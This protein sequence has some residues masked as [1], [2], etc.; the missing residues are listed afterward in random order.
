MLNHGGSMSRAELSALIREVQKRH[1]AVPEMVRG[2]HVPY[3]R[4]GEMSIPAFAMPAG[5]DPAR[6]GRTESLRLMRKAGTLPVDLFFFDC[7]DAAPDHPEY[8]AF[9][10][11]FAAE[12]LTTF[13][14]GDR[15]VGFRPNNIRTDYF[16][17]D[18]VQ[19]VT[20]AGHRLDVII[21][22]KTETADEISD[23][24]A[25][26]RR[27]QQLAGHTNTISFEVLVESPRAF[28]EAERI[29]AI[30]GVTALILG[31]FDL[32]RTIGGAV[33]P[34]T[35][36][37][38]QAGIRQYLPLAAAARGKEAV[39]AI[40]ATLPLRP[41]RPPS[42]TDLAYRTVLATDPA[43]IDTANLPPEFVKGL[44]SRW[45]A[46]TLAAL[47]AQSARRCGYS[48]K[49]I[50]HPDQIDPVQSAWTPSA[51]A[52]RE[53]LRLVAGYARAAIRGSG[54]ELAGNRL[55]D[56]A[57]VGADWWTVRAALRAGVL[58]TADIEGTGLTMAQ[59]ERTVRTRDA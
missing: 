43:Q 1:R 29:A 3:Y 20:G 52:A 18:L 17:E 9:A 38:D 10:R 35:W 34:G 45:K 11:T 48:A 57:V 44:C 12:A 40:T 42:M 59:L 56:K 22:P 54:V 49:W 31:S 5:G 8:K 33:D 24:I 14:F 39:D 23:I 15:I 41:P 55:A 6:D 50:L 30:D 21:I 25:I 16:E 47:E 19:V 37:E 36:M 46:M 53:A 26:T 28:F 2:M 4:R 51:T 13:D 7:E 32:A 58:K 27:A